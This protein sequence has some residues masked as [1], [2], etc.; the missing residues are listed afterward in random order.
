M[1]KELS[2]P[3]P[4]KGA[5]FIITGSNESVWL[6]HI[7]DPK[8]YTVSKTKD[9]KKVFNINPSKL[10]Q[11]PKVRKPIGNKPKPLTKEE[12][13][14]KDDLN[15]FYYDA[16]FEAPLACQECGTH[17][18]S[19]NDWEIRCCT[20]HILPKSKKSGFPSVACNQANKLFL[21]KKNCSCHTNYDE[22]GAEFRSKMK[23]YPVVLA[24]F[25]ILKEDLSDHDIIRA[26]KYLNI[27]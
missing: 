7:S 10:R 22:K 4:K 8:T 5:E 21:G 6:F 18:G 9:F 11:A 14:F 1:I 19:I 25:E 12:K 15:D 20:A 2:K 27:K 24:A 13:Q 17:L 16:S 26:K 3:K 23:V